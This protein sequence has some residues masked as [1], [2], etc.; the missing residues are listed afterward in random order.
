MFRIQTNAKQVAQQIRHLLAVVFPKIALK[1]LEESAQNIQRK[2][3]EPGKPIRYPVN[4]DSVRQRKA[5]FASNGFGEG[6]PYRRKNEH[7]N[8]WQMAPIQNGWQLSNS[9]PSAMFLFGRAD[10]LDISPGKK[11]SNI[12]KGRWP[13]FR[14]TVDEEV[15]KLPRNLIA[16]INIV[17]Q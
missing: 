10:G 7:V 3:A 1:V 4:W 15:Q 5:F 16:R 13:L 8:A 6:I 11:Q 2:M 14:P 17:D 12:H 9:K